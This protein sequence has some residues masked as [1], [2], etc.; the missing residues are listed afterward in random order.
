MRREDA[1]AR[2]E[3]P[4]L[5]AQPEVDPPGEPFVPPDSWQRVMGNCSVS[6]R[7]PALVATRSHGVDSCG[8]TFEGPD[9]S[10]IADVGGF[11]DTFTEYDSDPQYSVETVRVGHKNARLV[12]SRLRR[13]E[14]QRYFVAIHVPGP[15]PGG[16]FTTSA[17]IV[18]FCFSGA[19][20]DTARAVLQTVE[21]PRNDADW[22]APLPEN[23]SCTG[24]DI[25]AITGYRLG[26][27][28]VDAKTEVPGV[29]AL[30][31]RAHNTTGSGAMVCFVSPAGEYF[32]AHVAYGEVVAGPGSRRSSGALQS[33]QLTQTEEAQCDAWVAAL[34][35]AGAANTLTGERSYGACP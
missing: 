21:L 17:S 19:G 16:S 30:G 15:V 5:D 13:A 31:A 29:C 24:D 4:A 1:D 11:S 22:L 32:W 8:A 20:R 23:I 35:D 33:T 12:M 9:C 27:A 10:Y 18:A 6:L 14:D 3:S 7:A 25:R 28:C 26:K 34:P 2:G